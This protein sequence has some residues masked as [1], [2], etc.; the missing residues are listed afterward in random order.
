MKKTIEK[1]EM[2]LHYLIAQLSPKHCEVLEILQEKIDES[3]CVW[4][5]EKETVQQCVAEDSD[6]CYSHITTAFKD[7]QYK[8]LLTPVIKQGDA[9]RLVRGF[10]LVGWESYPHWAVQQLLNVPWMSKAEDAAV[11]YS[12]LLLDML[13][14][15]AN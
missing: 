9:G 6:Y 10:N 13:E 15:K 12:G 8:G 2:V 7:L 4:S 1:P 11:N 5:S 3:G 14:A